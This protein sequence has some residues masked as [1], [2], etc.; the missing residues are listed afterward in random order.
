MSIVC[1]TTRRWRN[2][3]SMRV[4]SM[5]KS[6]TELNS[7]REQK[8]IKKNIFTLSPISNKTDRNK[9]DLCESVDLKYDYMLLLIRF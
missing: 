7:R 8:N 4:P 5:I 6:I 3:D 2:C 9:K 1:Q